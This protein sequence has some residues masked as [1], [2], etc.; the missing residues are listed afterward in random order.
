[1]HRF[2]A[3][4]GDIA[5][6]KLQIT[7]DEAKHIKNALRMRPGDTL[8]AF[9]GT[10]VDYTCRITDVGET[11]QAVVSG[12][13]RNLCEPDIAVTLYQA[14]PKS[15]KM[16]EIVQKAVELGAASVVPF[17]SA[18]C[19]KKPADAARL[20][21]VALAAVKQCGRSLLPRVPDIVRFEDALERMKKHDKLIVCWEEERARALSAALA[22]RMRDIGVVIGPEGGFEKAEVDLMRAAGGES[23]T[24]GPR[25]LR[26]E[27]AGV[28]VLAAVM[29]DKG[30]M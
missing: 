12:K 15:A 25:I 24:L 28:A 21:R 9:D 10:G 27:T 18:R 14:Y 22:G 8:I 6:D 1:M 26:T 3:D 2:F 19:V 13:A 17:L 20:R 30:Q 7:G 23:V 11:V 5:G 16:E 29:Y 4:S